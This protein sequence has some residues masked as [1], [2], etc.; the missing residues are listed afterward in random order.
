MDRYIRI[1]I[2]AEQDYL[3]AGLALIDTGLR[4]IVG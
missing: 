2:G 4:D 3:L 1:G